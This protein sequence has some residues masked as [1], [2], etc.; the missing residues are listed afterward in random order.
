MK[1][2]ILSLCLVCIFTVLII[3]YAHAYPITVQ[4]KI[5]STGTVSS[6][7]DLSL[8]LWTTQT[9]G[10]GTQVGPTIS[11]ASVSVVDGV[12][13]T[14]VDFG[15]GIDYSKKYFIQ[16]S[17]GG[18]LLT[19]RQELTAAPYASANVLKA[20]DVMT[21]PLVVTSTLPLGMVVVANPYGAIISSVSTT[22]ILSGQQV[23]REINGKQIGVLSSGKNIGGFFAA[24]QSE[25]GVGLRAI[26]YW[27]IKASGLY[28]GGSFESISPTD[29]GYG[30]SGRSISGVGV[31]GHSDL[32]SGVLGESNSNIG[33]AGYSNNNIG[34]LGVSLLPKTDPINP[35]SIGVMGYAKGTGVYGNGEDI[36]VF[37]SSEGKAGVK[38]FSNLETG[39]I[40]QSMSGDGMYAQSNLGNGI[41][42]VTGV[43]I[44][45]WDPKNYGGAFVGIGNNNGVFGRGSTG[46][47]FIG[48]EH[49]IVAQSG[50][51]DVNRILLNKYAGVFYGK[52]T[53]RGLGVFGDVYSTG[54]FRG[55]QTGLDIA[56]WIKS[57]DASVQ[58]GDVVI[59]NPGEIETVIKSR[60]PYSTL[61]A[62]IISTNPGYLAGNLEKG[63][64]LL[65][66]EEIEKKGYRMLALAGRV[67]CNVSA[68]NGPIEIGDLL[69][70]SSTPG[71]AM[72]VTDKIKAM[73][74]I[75]GKALEPLKEGKGKITVLVTLQ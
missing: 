65:D 49:G 41:M 70:T 75:V 5:S 3:T 56:E 47:K 30:V 20:G 16:I 51:D 67:P 66:K 22:E 42:G 24:S 32:G 27:G 54:V 64:E 14:S 6:L 50:T 48:T 21:G 72:K 39:V 74:A 29:G 9:V 8:S 15:N 38:G 45:V 35:S 63:N 11:R 23:L 73:G 53:S 13:N 10:T 52:G 55:G 17:V 71:Y 46:G 57:S 28:F 59:I 62:G 31:K 69:T 44:T 37:G 61:V 43:G 34:M 25:Y 19:P 58:A 18:S 60:A 33:V 26:G 36:G 2:S 7:I 4:G 40:G 1:K 68:E 12:F